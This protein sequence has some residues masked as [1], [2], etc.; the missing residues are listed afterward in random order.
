MGDFAH[1]C[2]LMR[3]GLAPGKLNHASEH[4]IF[5]LALFLY[6][7]LCI[8]I[9][10][11]IKA[12]LYISTASFV[13]F[14]SFAQCSIVIHSCNN[15]CRHTYTQEHKFI[16]IYSHDSSIKEFRSGDTSKAMNT[17]SIQILA[18]KYHLFHL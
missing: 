5:S 18:S 1:M 17:P 11:V 10:M 6:F 4:V 13:A 14:L 9:S 2:M 8:S 3:G 7:Y 15:Q 12:T 16:Y